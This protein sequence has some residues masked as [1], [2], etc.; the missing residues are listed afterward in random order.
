MEGGYF[1]SPFL[2]LPYDHL[3]MHNLSSVVTDH[4]SNWHNQQISAPAGIFF[5]GTIK[6]RFPS[7][8]SA[9]RI[10]PSDTTPANLAGFKLV[11]TI[12]FFPTI[13][14]GE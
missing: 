13:S 10:M 14:S 7:A 2:R 5:S 1:P 12:T 3:L 4:R 9:H 6:D 8:S 11:T